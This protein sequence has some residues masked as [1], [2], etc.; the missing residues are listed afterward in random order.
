MNGPDRG[1]DQRSPWGRRRLA[2][3][4]SML[5]GVAIGAGLWLGYPRDSAELELVSHIKHEPAALAASTTLGPT[6]L[7]QVLGPFGMALRDE[8]GPVTFAKRCYWQGQW[9]P[10]LVVR[11][12]SGPVTVMLL[13]HRTIVEAQRFDVEGYAGVMLP[14]PRGSVAI[15]GRDVPGLQAIAEQ[16]FS[17]VDWDLAPAAEATTQGPPGPSKE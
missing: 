15:I 10:H 5:L 13:P 4:A 14:A 7:A 8:A 9:V 11:T 17:A 6:E 3:V 12:A 16:V 2:L 1:M